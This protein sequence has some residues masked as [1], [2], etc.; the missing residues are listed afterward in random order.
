[1]FTPTEQFI[2]QMKFSELRA[3][4]EKAL[5]AYDALEQELTGAKDDAERLRLLYRGLRN[6][7]FAKQPLHPDVANL[8]PLLRELDTGQALSETVSFWI[9]QLECE[10]ARGRM[11]AEVV[12]I[13][14]ALLEERSQDNAPD[15]SRDEERLNAQA[16]IMSRLS[17]A[18]QRP[19]SRSFAEQ[20]FDELQLP[21]GETQAA[22]VRK[23]VEEVIYSNA[24]AYATTGEG[25]LETA[26]KRI[27]ADVYRS[28]AIRSQA[29]HFLLNPT[30]LKELGDALTLMIDHL[31]EWNWPE[32]GVPA[33]TL[34]AGNKWRLFLDEDLPAACALEVLGARW[35]KAIENI[36]AGPRTE[37]LK[38]LQRLQ[39]IGAP[40]IIIDS[41]M[42]Q[43]VQYSLPDDLAVADIWADGSEREARTDIGSGPGANPFWGELGSIY[44]QRAMTQGALRAFDLSD[45]YG[46][47]IAKSGLDEA[48][49]L[50]NAEIQV[51]RAAFPG[52]PLYVLKLDIK[53]FYASLQHEHVLSLL[54]RLV[55]QL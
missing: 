36:W 5:K 22:H 37:R 52:R 13:F 21:T 14:G 33:H 51:S 9:E 39:E 55:L 53:D 50:N 1:M 18:P 26:L 11:C 4:R 2:T 25:E 15:T 6:L 34:W 43:I 45:G 7:T 16:T 20:I 28:G 49:G 27:H 47:T 12:Y 17:A 29:Q 8:E 19:D 41:E 10:L 23:V 30:L 31:D 35:Q 54:A 40:A 32:D 3:Q 24:F 44:A 46:N 42:A 38:R 48:L